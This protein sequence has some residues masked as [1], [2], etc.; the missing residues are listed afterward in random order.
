MHATLDV[1]GSKNFP[2]VINTLTDNATLAVDI[3]TSLL[4]TSPCGQLTA[5]VTAANELLIGGG[6][7]ARRYPCGSWP[8]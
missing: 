4:A 5:I 8:R 6:G 3:R 7:V 1:R 2:D